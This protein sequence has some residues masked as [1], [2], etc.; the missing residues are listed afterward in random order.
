MQV[1]Y[2]VV[3][4][5]NTTINIDNDKLIWNV[6]VYILGGTNITSQGLNTSLLQ[7]SV[8]LQSHPITFSCVADTQLG[9]TSLSNSEVTIFDYNGNYSFTIRRIKCLETCMHVEVASSS[10]MHAHTHTY[11]PT[12]THTCL[13]LLSLCAFHANAVCHFG[14]RELGKP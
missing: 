7:T 5:E 12:C 3:L 8:R 14:N 4:F 9:M 10:S 1:K 6:N 13:S 11:T 2:Q